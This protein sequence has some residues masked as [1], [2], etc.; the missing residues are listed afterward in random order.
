MLAD[1]DC[2][3]DGTINMDEWIKG[4]MNNIPFLVLLG[5]DVVSCH[6][7]HF[8]FC[9]CYYSFHILLLLLFISYFVTRILLMMIGH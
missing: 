7:C 8:I 1:M 6:C 5:L 9:Y 3:A 4:G 2:D